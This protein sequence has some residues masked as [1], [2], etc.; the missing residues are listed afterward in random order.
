LADGSTIWLNAASKLSFPV[1]FTDSTRHI[2]LEG[3][4]YFE[5]AHNGS[6]FIVTTGDMDIRVMGTSFNVSAYA[7]DVTKKTTL[8]E[9]KVRVDVHQENKVFQEFLWP[10]KQAIVGTG[11]SEIVITDVDAQ[12]YKSWVDGKFEFNNETLD[13]VMKKLARWYNFKYEFSNSS[14][15]KFH[16]SGRLNNQ[17]KISSI[18]NMLEMTTNVT[19]IIQNNVIVIK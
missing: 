4:A 3:E 14:A 2:F 1:A 7:D 16:F 9:G 11:K 19:F 15:K 10:N 5:V 18:L 17:E 6:P 13:H 12:Q 8:V